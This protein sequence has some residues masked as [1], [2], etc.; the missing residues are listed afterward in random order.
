LAVGSSPELIFV[1]VN[2][3]IAQ[4][5]CGKGFV[6]ATDVEISVRCAVNHAA[7]KVFAATPAENTVDKTQKKC[8]TFVTITYFRFIRRA[9][10]SKWNTFFKARRYFPALGVSLYFRS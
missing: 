9:R 4:N 3:A 7:G 10:R 8:Q 6:T 5:C 2:A 1:P